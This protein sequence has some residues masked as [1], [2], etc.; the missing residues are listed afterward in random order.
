MGKPAPLKR[1]KLSNQKRSDL[2]NLAKQHKSVWAQVVRKRRHTIA[3]ALAENPAFA[4]AA[5]KAK[6]I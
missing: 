4:K 3:H 2:V 1:K 5:K 6:L